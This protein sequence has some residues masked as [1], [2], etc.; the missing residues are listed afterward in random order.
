MAQ[1]VSVDRPLNVPR[2]HR[3]DCR[4]E[5]F[6]LN[7][8]PLFAHEGQRHTRRSM[9]IFTCRCDKFMKAHVT[10]S[11]NDVVRRWHTARYDALMSDILPAAG[12]TSGLQLAAA[13]S[14]AGKPRKTCAVGRSS[15]QQQDLVVV[16]ARQ[17]APGGDRARLR[18]VLSV[19]TSRPVAIR[20]RTMPEDKPD[21]TDNGRSALHP[22]RTRWNSFGRV[23]Y[24][25]IIRSHGMID[26]WIRLLPY[27]QASARRWNF[28]PVRAGPLHGVRNV[29]DPDTLRL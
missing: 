22:S 29:D 27:A 7:A 6:V 10:A 5:S 28:E 8:K 4:G 18:E 16:T 25:K 17:L 1:G 21:H 19:A 23:D 20:E 15:L 11:G 26:T 13:G 12:I 2:R 9:H 14:H 3:D 24:Q